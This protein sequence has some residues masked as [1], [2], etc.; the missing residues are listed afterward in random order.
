MRVPSSRLTL[1]SFKLDAP[2]FAHVTVGIYMHWHE[3]GCPRLVGEDSRAV[4]EY[5][6]APCLETD[7]CRGAH[8]EELLVGV[9]QLIGCLVPRLM[10]V[11]VMVWLLPWPGREH[12]VAVDEEP[13]LR[14]P[15]SLIADAVG[16]AR[17]ARCGADLHL[18][19]G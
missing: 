6:V 11:A 8:P 12:L 14:L 18:R 15:L 17:R 10:K 7:L 4:H 5:L 2:I 16:D 1:K 19:A 13:P 3:S 9:G